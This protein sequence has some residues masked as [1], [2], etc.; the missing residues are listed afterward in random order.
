MS[1]AT[2]KQKNFVQEYNETNAIRGQIHELDNFLKSSYKPKLDAS[3]INAIKL[4]LRN[5]LVLIQGPPGTGM[6]LGICDVLRFIQ[7][8]IHYKLIHN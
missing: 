1:K 4:A 2:R 6:Y 7:N 8:Y 3:Q 5:R